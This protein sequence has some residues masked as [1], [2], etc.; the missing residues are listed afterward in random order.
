[1]SQRRYWSPGTPTMQGS[2]PRRIEVQW[3]LGSIPFVGLSV[4]LQTC[5][6]DTLPVPIG[7]TDA[8]A[9]KPPSEE[10]TKL[11]REPKKSVKVLPVSVSQAAYQQPVPTA[12][13]RSSGENATQ[14]TGEKT[15]LL[16][17]VS[18][19][20]WVPSPLSTSH[21]RTPPDWSTDRRWWPSVELAR[22]AIAPS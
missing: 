13:V 16:F 11:P 12:T 1:N 10:Y 5:S 14:L 6:I 4:S 20:S 22:A 15:I 3:N 7:G 21:R 18:N 2:E 17:P 9:S 8:L 19:R